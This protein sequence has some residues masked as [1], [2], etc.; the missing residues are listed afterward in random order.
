MRRRNFFS[1]FTKSF[2]LNIIIALRLKSHFYTVLS[3]HSTSV[4]FYPFYLHLKTN[5]TVE[6][7]ISWPIFFVF[8]SGDFS[9]CCIDNELAHGCRLEKSLVQFHKFL[10][11]LLYRKFWQFFANNKYSNLNAFM[12]KI[13]SQNSVFHQ[14]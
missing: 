2:I 8:V 4:F 12:I 6:L 7:K 10:L 11:W 14:S 3:Y 13:S 5:K 1:K 9:D